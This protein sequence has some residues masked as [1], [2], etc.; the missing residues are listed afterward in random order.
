ARDPRTA[1]RLRALLNVPIGGPG[2][3]MA[4]AGP[5]GL[6]P[7]ALPRMTARGRIEGSS[8]RLA[9][10]GGRIALGLV[11]PAHPVADTPAGRRRLAAVR[12]GGAALG[13]VRVSAT[14]APA[15]R[16]AYEGAIR[17]DLAL[18]SIVSMAAILALFGLFFRSLRMLPLVALSLA[19]AY[20]ITLGLWGL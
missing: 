5:L 20:V 16:L 6:Y 2:A 8:G 7:L 14:G 4:R 9:S 12:R 18:S 11:A 1:R 13:R 10:K 15:Y 19:L 17:R 3:E